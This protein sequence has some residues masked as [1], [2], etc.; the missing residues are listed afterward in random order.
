MLALVYDVHGNLP[1]LEAVL[2]DARAAGADE[3]LLGGDYSGLGAW[4]AETLEMLDGLENATWLRG[5]WERWAADAADAPGDVVIQGGLAAV[6][7]ALDEAAIARLAAL[8]QQT[9]RGPAR[10]CH[11]SP[12][13]DMRS[14][15]PDPSDEDGELLQ[16][17]RERRVV[18]GH[19][20]LAFARADASGVEIVN[21]GSVGMPLDGDVRAAY[22]LVDDGGTV[23]HRRVAYDHAAA[24]SELRKRCEASW[25]D[26]IADRLE[27]AS[28]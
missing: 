20:H 23:G 22:A 19:T 10:Y 8:P 21:P 27:R 14:F 11:G 9:V 2:G 25:A 17:V 18:V 7:G 16:G 12:V 28:A 3:W 6:R 26:P 13:S 1:A 4:P 5:N 24:A 15:L